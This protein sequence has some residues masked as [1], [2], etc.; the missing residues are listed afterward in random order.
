[1]RWVRLVW[2]TSI[3]NINIELNKLLWRK[4]RKTT[5]KKYRSASNEQQ[6]HSSPHSKTSPSRSIWLQTTK[7]QT[8]H[9]RHPN[10][11][12]NLPLTSPFLIR[13]MTSLSMSPWSR[14]SPTWNWPTSHRRGRTSS[15]RDIVRIRRR[16]WSVARRKSKKILI[17]G[18]Q[19]Q[20]WAVV[21]SLWKMKRWTR[22]KLSLSPMKIWISSDLKQTWMTQSW[23]TTSKCSTSSSYLNISNKNATSTPPSSSKNS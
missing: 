17:I 2:H 23:V 1:M 18:E 7:W 21:S 10:R 5:K 9:R 13:S 8:K 12:R 20:S 3:A 4:P 11:L 16:N 14:K 19:C 6:T 15:L 22:V